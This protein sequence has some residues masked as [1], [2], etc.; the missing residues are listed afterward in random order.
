MIEIPAGNK[1]F[2]V[3]QFVRADGLG[4]LNGDETVQSATVVAA[5]Y[6]AGA[7]VANLVSQVAPYNGTAVRYFVDPAAAELA[8][9]AQIVLTFAIVTS[10]GQT[11]TD[12]LHAR[13]T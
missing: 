2:R 12:V 6:P 13:I 8:A 7:S 10:N 5:R 9:G 3:F 1:E 4:Q 11:L